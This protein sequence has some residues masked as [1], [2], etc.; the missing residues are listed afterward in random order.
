MVSESKVD[1]S[2]IEVINRLTKLSWLVCVNQSVQDDML[3]E[4]LEQFKASP[5]LLY[6]PPLERLHQ[7]LEQLRQG[8]SSGSGSF[9]MT[10][11]SAV[12]TCLR[13]L[14]QYARVDGAHVLELVVKAA[15]ASVKDRQLQKVADVRVRSNLS[16]CVIEE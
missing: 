16:F 1:V 8:S 10:E 6:P 12:R 5:Q 11:T 13:E 3:R 15:L 7:R 2:R 9:A 14:Y 4:E